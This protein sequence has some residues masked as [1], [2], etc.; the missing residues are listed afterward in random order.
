MS[1]SE[2][3]K[4]TFVSI[5]SESGKI[6]KCPWTSQVPELR[7]SPAGA[8]PEGDCQILCMLVCSSVVPTEGRSV[9]AFGAAEIVTQLYTSITSGSPGL[10]AGEEL[11]TCVNPWIGTVLTWVQLHRK[12][13]K[14]TETSTDELSLTSWL[15]CWH[16]DYWT[17]CWSVFPSKWVWLTKPFPAAG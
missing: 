12:G 2:A 14:V 15:K 8:L 16:Q 3:G 10:R 1:G 5:N 6:Q 13:P 17:L 4:K 11:V 9:S 7:S